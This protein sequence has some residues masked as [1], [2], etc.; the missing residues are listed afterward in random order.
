[1]ACRP[2]LRPFEAEGVVGQ[3]GTGISTRCTHGQCA[4]LIGAKRVAVS[5]AMG[6][7]STPFSDS[8]EEVESRWLALHLAS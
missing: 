2:F 3:E 1:M 4:A 7:L 6:H 8:V 5:R